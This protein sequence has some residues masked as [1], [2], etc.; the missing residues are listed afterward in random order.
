MQSVGTL[1]RRP[2]DK[3]LDY[4]QKMQRE[5]PNIIKVVSQE[6]QGISAARNQGIECA[7]GEYIGFIDHD[8]WVSELYVERLIASAKKEAADV[9]KCGYSILSEGKTISS[10]QM[11]SNVI[12]G[13]MG[14]RIFQYAG[15]IWGGIYRRSLFDQIRFPVG[16]WYEDM[17]SRILVYRQSMKFVNVGEE[18]YY[19]LHHKRNAS[20]VV[21][22]KKEYKTLEQLYL[23]EG[24]VRDNS[25]LGLEEDAVFYRCILIECTDIMLIR[26]SGLPESMKKQIFLRINQMLSNLFCDGYEKDM[27]EKLK[28]WNK[29]I[30]M[31]NY[32]VWKLMGYLKT[33]TTH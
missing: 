4:A 27:P 31:K 8:D 7:C 14:E 10:H 24:I 11:K 22:S 29:A 16:F 12:E 13:K 1:I 23:T 26:I 30:L 3:S 21:W 32:K 25:K 9:V 15:Y 2:T 18:L 17:I 28:R 5:Y 20:D 33:T 6:N 19:K